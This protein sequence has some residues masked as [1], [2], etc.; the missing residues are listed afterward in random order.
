MVRRILLATDGSR[1]AAD[2]CRFLASLPLPAG[3]E[4]RVVCVVDMFVEALL[5]AAQP[6]Q[7]DQLQLLT[8]VAAKALRRD[9]IEVGSCLLSGDADH[10]IIREAEEWK[11]DLVVVGSRGLTSLEEFV[12][13]SVATNVAKHAPCPVLIARTPRYELHTVLI[14][15]DGSSHGSRAT[16]FAADLPLPAQTGF[17]LIHVVRPPNP[18]VDLAS[19]GEASL[20]DVLQKDQRA[21]RERGELLLGMG[22]SLLW[23]RGREATFQVRSGD[24][25]AQILEAAEELRADLLVLGARGT[26]SIRGL[27]VGSVAD[28]VLRHAHSSV[29]IVR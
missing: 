4:I 14:A 20:Y 26:S 18:L 3:T 2:A 7:R 9:G 24:P 5:E 19:I 28:R 21:R 12:L 1:Y 25:A 17:V 15:T 16:E 22:A 27:V 11:A 10:Q 29:L 6:N 13:G 23:D 8:E